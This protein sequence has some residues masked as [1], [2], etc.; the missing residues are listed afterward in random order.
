LPEYPNLPFDEYR[1]QP[2]FHQI[3]TES[4]GLQLINEEPYIFVVPNFFSTRECDE[5]IKRSALSAQ[6]PSDAAYAEQGIRTSTTVLLRHTEVSHLRS[7]IAKL[8]NVSL[9]QFQPSKLS[10]YDPGQLFQEHTD[11]M[12]PLRSFCA[13]TSEVLRTPLAFPNRHVT[14]WIYLNDVANG[15]RTN[16]SSMNERTFYSVKLPKTAAN[17]GQ[18]TGP[19]GGEHAWRACAAKISIAPVQGMAVVHFPC[20]KIEYGSIKDP[21]A[22]HEGAVAVDPKFIFQQF[23]WSGTIDEHNTTYHEGVR[24][25]F[26]EELSG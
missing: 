2:F 21:N 3:N 6:Q 17:L 25:F 22:H 19:S 20:T 16:F 14:V 8:V 13:K 18:P 26:A 9:D 7:R 24:S 15:G 23:I 12:P 1:R 10:R 5:L 4:P 11:H